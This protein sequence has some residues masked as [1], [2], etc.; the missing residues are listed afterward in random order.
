MLVLVLWRY[1]IE[2][3]QRTTTMPPF[4]LC[5]P[6]TGQNVSCRLRRNPTHKLYSCET[7][8]GDNSFGQSLANESG[9]PVTAPNVPYLFKSNVHNGLAAGGAWIT[10]YP[11][12]R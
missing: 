4:F 9:Q 3:M 7:G 6:T 10:F 8:K 11:N 5:W 1:H 2:A 12:G